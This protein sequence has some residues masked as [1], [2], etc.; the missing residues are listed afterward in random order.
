MK[1]DQAV[2]H[3]FPSSRTLHKK[4]VDCARN[5]NHGGMKGNLYEIAAGSHD[6]DTYQYA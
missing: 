1:R 2:M 3:A 6:M 5:I 4:Q